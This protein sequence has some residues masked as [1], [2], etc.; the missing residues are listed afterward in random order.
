MRAAVNTQM[1]ITMFFSVGRCVIID[2]IRV[3]TA[4]SV[5]LFESPSSLMRDDGDDDVEL[6][7]DA[8]EETLCGME[9]TRQRTAI[10]KVNVKLYVAMTL[11]EDNKRMF[12]QRYFQVVFP[13][14]TTAVTL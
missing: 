9:L 13:N 10:R 14:T 4:E 3:P 7:C 5:M 1:K 11:R 12:S 2:E 6:T 8:V